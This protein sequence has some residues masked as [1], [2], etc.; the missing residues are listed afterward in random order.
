MEAR[1]DSGYFPG[2]KEGQPCGVERRECDYDE[3]G[4]LGVDWSGEEIFGVE[5]QPL[6][7]LNREFR[8][9]LESPNMLRLTRLSLASPFRPPCTDHYPHRQASAPSSPPVPPSTPTHLFAQH[10]HTFP[11]PGCHANTPTP[12]S[13]PRRV[14]L[15]VS[16]TLRRT[17]TSP[18]LPSTTPSPPMCHRPRQRQ[19]QLDHRGSAGF[20]CSATRT[21]GPCCPTLPKR[22]GRPNASRT[23]ATGRSTLPA[24]SAGARRE[25]KPRRTNK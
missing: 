4:K 5:G 6:T 1:L 15:A 11:A 19:S 8:L 23:R 2:A 24:C 21:C 17:S 12:T 16:S 22:S 9:L 10:Y 13:T 7:F 25:A 20:A 14:P 18:P 3:L